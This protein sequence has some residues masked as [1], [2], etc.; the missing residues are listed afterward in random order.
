[1]DGFF[2]TAASRRKRSF[3]HYRLGSIIDSPRWALFF[4]LLAIALPA[5]GMVIALPATGMARTL[6]VGPS[7]KLTGPREAAL[8]AAD[9]DRIVF[10][11][12]VYRDCAIWPAS[13]LTIE[14]RRPPATMNQTIMSQVIVTGPTCGNR[15][16]FV[17]IGNDITVRGM[18]FLHA[19]DTWHTG[20]GILMEGA[21]L[22][23]ENSQFLDDENG[24]LAGGPPISVVRV[25]HVLF[26][27]NGSCEGSCAHAL[28]AGAQIARLEV[29][30]CTFIDTHVGHNVKSR[31]R[32]TIVR[33]SRI[34]DGPTGTSSYLIELPD[35]GD[36]TIVNNVL[37]K[38][39]LT[40]NRE[41][42][43]SIGTES[44]RNPTN[45]LLVRGN[46][47]TSDLADPVRFVR[48]LTATPA[49]LSDNTLIGN[50]V[51][52]DGAGTVE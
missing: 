8:V 6:E 31:A 23:V 40:G 36:G 44:G 11:A 16:L 15:G 37:Q 51:P 5:A 19:R 41:A 9:G 32:A 20:A 10:D 3:R 18:I 26:R 42:A 12:G 45:A 14:A 4:W 1:M 7:R 48:N 35:G 13:R 47:F 21:N 43:I 17:F 38:G 50:V 29:I 28:Y 27:G 39:V 25:S 22:T 46:R 30:G 2:T 33:D 24:I 34:E 49:R 52:L